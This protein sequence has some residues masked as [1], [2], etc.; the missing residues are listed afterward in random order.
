MNEHQ[1][2]EGAV[3]FYKETWRTARQPHECSFCKKPVSQGDR[4]CVATMKSESGIIRTKSCNVCF[5]ASYGYEAE[6]RT[7]DN[8]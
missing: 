5:M 6:E 3:D 2:R 4:Y 1:E 7:P 8:R